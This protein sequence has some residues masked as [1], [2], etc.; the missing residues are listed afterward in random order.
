MAKKTHSSP[1]TVSGGGKSSKRNRGSARSGTRAGGGRHQHLPAFD[2]RRP[3]SAVDEAETEGG[4]GSEG[5]PQF[6]NAA[7]LTVTVPR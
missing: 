4:R 7:R 6:M 2:D 5:E 1:S 3:E